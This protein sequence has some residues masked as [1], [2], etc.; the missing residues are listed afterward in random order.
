MS[1]AVVIINYRTPQYTID[2]LAS[3]EPER[4]DVPGL[5]VVLVENASGDDSAD[6]ISAA[7]TRRG[8]DDWVE[9]LPQT[10]N[11][12]FAGGN[13]AA[14]DYLGTEPNPPEFILL[15][16]SDTLVRRGCLRTSLRR[17]A[18][19][20]GIGALSCMLR[21]RD[22]SVQNVCR[23]FAT[24]LRE[25]CRA[26]G[27]PYKLPRLFHWAELE[28]AGWNRET[29][30]RDVEWI[31]GAYMMIRTAML[32][33][34][35]NL[36]TA[37]FFYGE[38]TEFCHRAWRHGWRVFFDPAGEIVHFGGGSSD[39]T[40]LP[41]RRRL[42]LAWK[43]RLLVQKKCHGRA[44]ALWIRLVY[45]L[46]LG[47]RLAARSLTGGRRTAGYERAAGDLAVL[48]RPLKA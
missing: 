46:A 39:P 31:G 14:L 30:A 18:D 47:A 45:T 28:D 9:I 26:L 27:L 10:R 32:R 8:W 15:L 11:L 19:E 44:A 42:V 25:T 43:A 6:C 36:D 21:N 16:N 7:I 41:D 29:T 4:T 12:G 35:G 3:L 2:C 1:L 13:N 17:M 24:P 48:V 33:Q 22:G 37:F 5:R 23:K 40:R 38:D 34:I 20:T